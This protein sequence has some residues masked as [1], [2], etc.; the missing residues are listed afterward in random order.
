MGDVRPGLMGAIPE[1]VLFGV[2][3]FLSAGC[4]ELES[5]SESTSGSG[6]TSMLAD[7][8]WPG[9]SGG[10]SEPPPDFLPIG[11]TYDQELQ[12]IAWSGPVSAVTIQHKDQASLPPDEGGGSCSSGCTEQVTRIEAGGSVWGRFEGGSTLSVQLG[13]ITDASAGT[14]I[15]TACGDTVGSSVLGIPGASTPGFSNFPQPAW[16]PPT[17]GECEWRVTAQD[18]YALFRAVTVGEAP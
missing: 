1:A 3:A 16:I 13:Q 14:A 17:T 8:D 12:Y 10:Y 4:L 7:A 18:G 5:T 2:V 15:V 6:G 9:G 11:R